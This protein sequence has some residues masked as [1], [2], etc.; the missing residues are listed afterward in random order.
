MCKQAQSQGWNIK[1]FSP[2]LSLDKKVG[3][4]WFPKIWG[5]SGD[6]EASWGGS[7][8]LAGPGETERELE[9]AEV[10]VLALSEPT[11]SM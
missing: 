10:T 1:Q 11:L 5:A 6:S 7:S 9:I 2:W 3:V 4:T 8:G